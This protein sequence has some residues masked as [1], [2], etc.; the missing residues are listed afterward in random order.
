MNNASILKQ[1][2]QCPIHEHN[3]IIT[4]KWDNNKIK[5]LEK[6]CLVLILKE[7]S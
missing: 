5:K 7:W 1:L 4:N 3:I 2:L 6:H